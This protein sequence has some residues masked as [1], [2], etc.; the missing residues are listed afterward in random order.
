MV[1]TLKRPGGQ[2][3][4]NYIFRRTQTLQNIGIIT[5]EDLPITDYKGITFYADDRTISNATL[6]MRLNNDSGVNYSSETAINQTRHV[7]NPVQIMGIN[8]ELEGNIEIIDNG[9]NSSVGIKSNC[10]RN[11][12]SPA[13]TTVDVLTSG[14]YASSARITRIDLFSN[15]SQLFGNLYATILGWNR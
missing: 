14:S 1:I 8:T 10:I 4:K 3:F 6:L 12:R 9:I 15:A 11:R 7:I 2:N 13:L 5:F